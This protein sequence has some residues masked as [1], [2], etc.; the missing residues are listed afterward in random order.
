MSFQ[1]HF[2]LELP[3]PPAVVELGG[4]AKDKI[5]VATSA[6]TVLGF[7]KKG[8]QIFELNAALAEPVKTM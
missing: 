1:V 5:F 8:K 4:K 3:S 7:T 6:G 2:K